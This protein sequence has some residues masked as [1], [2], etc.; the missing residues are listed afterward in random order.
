[1]IAFILVVLIGLSIAAFICDGEFL[2]EG[3]NKFSHNA[4]GIRIIRTEF[5][6]GV[7]QFHL[8]QRGVFTLRWFD[9]HDSGRYSNTDV[10]K[11]STKENAEDRKEFYLRELNAVK[12]VKKEIIK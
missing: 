7:S 8:Q 5:K 2:K 4:T 11:Y 6:N 12:K 9:I 10:T 1:M 3:K